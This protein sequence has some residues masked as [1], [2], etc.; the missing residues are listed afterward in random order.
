MENKSR[1]IK[2]RKVNMKRLSLIFVILLVIIAV[3]IGILNLLIKAFSPEKVFGNYS[4]NNAG[5]AVSSGGTVYYN[6]YEEGIFKAKNK[7]ETRLTNE[8]AYSITLVK[9]TLYYLTISDSNTIDLKCINTNGEDMKTITT[10]STPIS[11]FYIEDNNVFYVS[12]RQRMK[13]A[14][15]SLENLEETTIIETGIQ[16]FVVSNGKIYYTFSKA[17]V[18]SFIDCSLAF[19]LRF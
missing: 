6:K 15:I 18:H 7:N 9:N 8:T 10:L 2:K 16:D 12:N 4:N 14:K 19:L 5:L 17:I 11:K 13:I 1:K 3:F